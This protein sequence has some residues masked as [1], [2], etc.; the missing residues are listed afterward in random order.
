MQLNNITEMSI[1]RNDNVIE[2]KEN[3]QIINIFNCKIK[4]LIIFSFFET[5]K[6]YS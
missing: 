3:K 2:H 6:S 4:L 5:D 1:I